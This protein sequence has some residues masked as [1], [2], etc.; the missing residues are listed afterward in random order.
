MKKKSVMEVERSVNFND[1][2]S[3]HPLETFDTLPELISVGV[4]KVPASN[5]Y[6]SF[7]MHTKE[8]RVTKLLVEEPNS[9]QI[10][11]DSAKI[12]FV[13]EFMAPHE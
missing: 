4:Y 12:S 8:G 5:A 11:E 7:T 1:D 3:Q 2:D 6:V 13:S 9:R 10:A